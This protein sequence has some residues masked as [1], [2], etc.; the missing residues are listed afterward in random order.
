MSAITAMTAITCDHGDF[1]SP[2]LHRL[3][4]LG[5]CRGAVAVIGTRPKSLNSV[6]KILFID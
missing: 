3:D 5:R 2:A 6:Q 1:L 4:E